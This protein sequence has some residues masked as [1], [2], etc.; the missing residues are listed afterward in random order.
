MESGDESTAWTIYWQNSLTG[1]GHCLP[2]A[3]RST[4]SALRSVWS[5]LG[6]RLVNAKV[7]DLGCGRGE[8]GLAILEASPQS[9][10][11]GVDYASLGPSPHPRLQ[12]FSQTRIEQ[13][14]FPSCYFDGA[15]SQF[16][17]EY[18]QWP[19]AIREVARV[20]RPDAPFSL[21]AHHADSVVAE[22]AARRSMALR[23]LVSKEV[24]R[25]LLEGDRAAF[26][27]EL[28]KIRE[29]TNSS[30]IVDEF[31]AGLGAFLNEPASRRPALFGHV[32]NLARA[33]TAVLA[34]LQRSI[35]DSSKFDQ[36]RAELAQ[37]FTIVSASTLV[38]ENQRP[39]AWVLHMHRTA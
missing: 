23:S 24:E 37:F 34:A 35:W 4:R 5:A 27:K 21:I 7:L 32:R 25:T 8:V 38:T 31:A 12:F 1:T 17:L 3:P 6:E 2:D 22:Q 33:E 26:M 16:A 13:L 19:S 20:L 28:E 15:T 14:P 30:Q 29:L 9:L 10:V 36:R 11:T 18:A 39:L